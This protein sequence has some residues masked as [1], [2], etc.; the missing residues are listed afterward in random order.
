MVVVNKGPKWYEADDVKKPVPSRKHIHK[1]TK[2][3]VKPGAVLILLAGSYRGTRVVF[4][5]QL[6]SGLLLVTGPFA[7]NG[8]P[9]KR[10]NQSFVIGTSTSVDI[11]GVDLKKFDDKYFK[12]DKKVKKKKE[13]ME[14]DDTEEKGKKKAPS[15]ERIKDQKSVDDILVKAIEKE[16]MLSSYMKS[17]FTLK[18]GQYPHEMTF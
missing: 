1:P 4:L 13:V 10:V 18:K 6:A 11:S 3:R 15:E 2:L 16:A 8:V 7:L 17:K 5:K 9:L 12:T 14:T